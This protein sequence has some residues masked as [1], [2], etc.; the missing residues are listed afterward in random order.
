MD[1]PAR[2]GVFAATVRHRFRPMVPED[3]RHPLLWSLQARRSVAR[4]I[5]HAEATWTELVILQDEEIAFREAFPDEDA[6]RLR[7]TALHDR[8]LKKGWR[9]AS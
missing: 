4:C 6:A 9:E 7:A 2:R 3:D 8:L 5:L 1:S